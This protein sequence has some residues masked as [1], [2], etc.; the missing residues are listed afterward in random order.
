MVGAAP[1]G[2]LGERLLD[3]RHALVGG[4]GAQHRAGLLGQPAAFLDDVQP[5]D[6]HAGGDQQPDRELAD[7]AET[8]DA[9]GVAELDLGAAH[10]VHGDRPDGGEGGVLG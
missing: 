2:E 4:R 10:A 8:D 7:E 1:V 5:D 6:A 9:G 3:R